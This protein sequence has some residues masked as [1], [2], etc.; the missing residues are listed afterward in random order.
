[1]FSCLRSAFDTDFMMFVKIIMIL[2]LK[3]NENHSLMSTFWYFIKNRFFTY[4]GF[5]GFNFYS[6]ILTIFVFFY[7]FYRPV[8]SCWNIF[9][10]LFSSEGK[11]TSGR[12]I[13][14]MML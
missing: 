12:L 6:D 7:E 9:L 1:M 14:W 2:S 10:F 4:S 13:L 8:S 11:W 3:N 5:K